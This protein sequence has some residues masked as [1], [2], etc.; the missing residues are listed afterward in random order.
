MSGLLRIAGSFKQSKAFIGFIT[1]G[2]GGIKR[3]LDAALALIEGGV[4]IMEIGLPFSDPIADGPVIQ[5][6]AARAIATGTTLQDAL[7]LIEN[8][9]R[10]SDIPLILFSYLNP[11]LTAMQ[12]NF[13]QEVKQAG[14]DGVLLVDCPLEE[15]AE[16]QEQCQMHQLAPVFLIAPNTS[17]A[18]IQKISQQGRGFLYY[19]CRK[20]TTGIRSSLPK[21]FVEKMQTIKSQVNL[22]VV[23]GFGIADRQSAKKVVEHADGVVVASLFVK[24][25]E[26]N[27]S[28]AELTRLARSINPFFSE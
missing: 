3:S 13:F 18:R 19:A 16:F 1:A 11:I 7:W 6:A 14:G 2:D 15:S 27:C 17:K 24:A 20:G 4:N 10:H 26:E 21:D 9:R 22:P 8:I 23:A 28:D 12:G 5:R 25:I